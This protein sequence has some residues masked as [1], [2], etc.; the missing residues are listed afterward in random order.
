MGDVVNLDI[1]TLADMPAEKIL[2]AAISQNLG[3]ALVVGWR[4]NGDLYFAGTTSNVAEVLLLLEMA[5]KE[6]LE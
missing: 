5:K 1:P 3:E 4:E 6:I 2:N